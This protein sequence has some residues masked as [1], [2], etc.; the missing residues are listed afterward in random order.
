MKKIL[1]FLS[2]FL[3]FN[4]SFFIPILDQQ[5]IEVDISR[6]EDENISIKWAV[7]YERYDFIMIEISH[8]N[9]I[10]KYELPGPTG[11]IELC[12]YPDYV[13]VTVKHI[14]ITFRESAISTENSLL[15]RKSV[16][17][18]L[19]ICEQHGNS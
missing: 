15:M 14:I 16:E 3:F 10:E 6:L 5:N 17:T 12:C 11:E 2:F 8:D 4:A 9:Q 13:K 18:P 1:I 7:A 19:D